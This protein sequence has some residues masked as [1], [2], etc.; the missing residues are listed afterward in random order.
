MVARCDTLENGPCTAKS[1]TAPSAS[2]ESIADNNKTLN[3]DI[4]ISS[5]SEPPLRRQKLSD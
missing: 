2:I 3:V 5:M 4:D 1:L